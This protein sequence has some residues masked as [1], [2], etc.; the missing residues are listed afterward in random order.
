[1]KL[2]PAALSLLL[3]LTVT[4]AL[5]DQKSDFEAARAAA[6]KPTPSQNERLKALAKEFASMKIG[7]D[8]DYMSYSEPRDNGSNDSKV[9][10]YGSSHH[11]ACKIVLY[12]EAEHS[13][14]CYKKT[15]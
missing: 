15:K 11:N 2:F 5:A 1:M 8:A 9:V 3:I 4:N 7:I 12:V 6:Q 14:E 10:I 13:T